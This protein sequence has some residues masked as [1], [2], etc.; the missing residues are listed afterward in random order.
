GP[1]AGGGPGG[2]ACGRAVGHG[3]GRPRRGSTRS[4]QAGWKAH[5]PAARGLPDLKTTT[6]WPFVSKYATGSPRSP[7]H[8]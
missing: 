2:L 8:L 1:G 5:P 3:A 7:A 4:P 6:S